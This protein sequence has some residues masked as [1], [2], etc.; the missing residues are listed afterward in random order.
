MKSEQFPPL[1]EAKAIGWRANVKR[2]L[3]WLGTHDLLPARAVTW[4]INALGLRNA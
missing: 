2:Q 4:L 3:V 1:V